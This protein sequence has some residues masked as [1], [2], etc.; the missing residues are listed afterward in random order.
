MTESLALIPS[1]VE[2]QLNRNAAFRELREMVLNSVASEHSKRNYGKALDEVYALCEER[3]QPLSR[4]L[5]MEYRAAMLEKRLSASTVNVRLS[6]IRKLIGEAL[7][8]G[9][10]GAEEAA[11]L[12]GVPNLSQK[13]TRLG[14]WLTRD[15][16]K[17][18]LRVPDRSKIK[19]K[20]DYVILALLL[21]C[22][23]R[24]QELAS[25]DVD[26]IQMRE[27]RWVLPDL[28]GKGGRVRTVAIPIWVKHGIDA[29]MVEA[30]I[31]DGR[32]LRPLSKGGKLIGDELG[33][34]AVW[35]VVEQ[36]A[37]EIGI[38]HFGA[39]D[40]RRTCAKLCRKNGGDLE[41]IKFLLGHSS[42]QTTERYLGSEQDLTVAVN[43]NLGL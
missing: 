8:N 38:E 28:R 40:L 23:L 7:R 1:A 5:L 30:K 20:R 9:I 35:S 42:I 18:L 17:E 34:W 14:N 2:S 26:R 29:W 21:G 33:D 22:A 39:H 41:Q 16:A 3:K 11:N 12:A 31:E 15:Q 24:R 13:G 37:K 36:S 32:L 25:L 27:G 43:D 10:I 4:A 6:A 19:G